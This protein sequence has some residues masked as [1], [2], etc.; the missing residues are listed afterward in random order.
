MPCIIDRFHVGRAVALVVATLGLV[1]SQASAATL[2]S[3]SSSNVG[4]TVFASP[5]GDTSYYMPVAGGSFE[6]NSL[7]KW[8]LNKESVVAGNEPWYVNSAKDTQSLSLTS[9]GSAV[10]PGV[11]VNSAR[12]WWRFFATSHNGATASTLSLWASWTNPDGT[13]GQTPVLTLPASGYQ[14]WTLSPQLVLGSALGTGINVT[15]HLHFSTTGKWQIDD[16][17]VDPY[18]KR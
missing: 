16:V 11:C 1:A 14:T 7:Q 9:G 4:T 2:S 17:Y 5:W 18:A 13:Q 3:C 15:A 10:S 8:T 6:S 12:P